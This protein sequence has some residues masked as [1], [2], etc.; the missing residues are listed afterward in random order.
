MFFGGYVIGKLEL[1]TTNNYT[2]LGS[3]IF[4]PKWYS[5]WKFSDAQY[6]ETVIF[7]CLQLLFNALTCFRLIYIKINDRSLTNMA[8]NKKEVKLAMYSFLTFA[9]QLMDIAYI[10]Y[11][12]YLIGEV[13][14]QTMANYLFSWLFPKS[15]LFMLLNNIWLPMFSERLRAG[16]KKKFNLINATK[17]EVHK[18]RSAHTR[19][20][21]IDA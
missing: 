21:K 18:S 3:G 1:Y 7:S 16:L 6:N 19:T 10:T 17:I 9:T 15:N 2:A 13:E 12:D 5:G 20:I 14:D 11:C 4:A 8:S